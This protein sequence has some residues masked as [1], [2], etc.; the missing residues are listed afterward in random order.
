[1]NMLQHMRDNS[2]GV[3][4]GILIG[5][6]VIIFAVS[7]AEALFQWDVNAKKAVT[8]NGEVISEIDV[9]RA[10]A[11]RKQQLM[12]R[13][14]ESVPADFLT[15]EKLR[16]PSIDGLIER[17]LLVQ[18]AKKTG[19]AASKEKIDKDIL[20]TTAFQK[21]GGVFDQTKF[22]QLL[23][24]QDFTPITYRKV[25]AEDAITSQVESGIVRSAFV[26]PA[27]L[28]Y[29]LGLSF[30]TRDF[31]YLVLPAEKATA[32]VVVEEADIKSH[33]EANPQTFTT[34]ERVA[35]DYIE[36]NVADL[37]KDVVVSDEQV[38][39]QYEQNTKSFVAKTERQ[40]AH[41]LLEGDAQKRA[42]DI[43]AKLA[44]GADFA[45][46]AKEYS[47]DSG[48][49]EQ[50]GD[51]GFS[52]GEAFPKEFEAA[53]ALLK[54]GEVSAPVKTEAGT[55]IIK[56]I[57]ER[58]SNP[59]SLEESKVAI[60]DQLKRTEAESQFAV[61]LGK[62]RDLSYNAEN[63]SDVAKELSL[64]VKN[65]GLFAKTGGTDLMA[66]S[67]FVNAAFS[68]EVLEQGNS[69]DVIE[70][71]ANRMVVLKKT[72][73]KPSQLE[74]LELVKEKIITT[75]R[76]EK[77]EALLTKQAKDL[78]ASLHSG[79]SI[80]EL[81]KQANLTAKS[82]AAVTRNDSTIDR[83]ISQFAFA[84][85]NPVENKPTLGKVKLASG[86][87]AVVS[88]KAVTLGTEDK[89][90]EEQR[91]AISTQLAGINGGYDMKSVQSHLQEVAKIKRK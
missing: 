50:G 56:L 68:P 31:S 28:K 62:L 3:I 54:V 91:K 13:F 42:E 22:V 87:L 27:E 84:L 46:L 30:Q 9:L 44:S 75:V 8:V 72:D 65:S 45:A 70:L 48:S 1:M 40:A 52:S 35:V 79:G 69:S 2:K 26:T 36:L 58:G 73:R 29:I 37:M 88:L 49:K 66:N 38:V 20:A 21:E 51:L 63:L 4:S 12:S 86:D 76:A 78:M 25:L 19:L 39:K 80:D 18:Y 23:A 15:D 77:A 6:L 16:Q 74:P 64:N 53:L 90:P 60:L 83:E 41:I 55:H 89:V 71:E 61:K 32:T 43:K 10:I 81:A 24:Y 47:S 33:Y 82:A 11:N 67:L 14:G 57:S 34:P 59:A 5:L 85:A 17:S 7:G